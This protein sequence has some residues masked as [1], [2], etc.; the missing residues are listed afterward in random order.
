[1]AC[2]I[3]F[4]QPS[5]AGLKESLH[6]MALMPGIALLIIMT[7]QPENVR[8]L[9]GSP[10]SWVFSRHPQKNIHYIWIEITSRFFTYILHG[11]FARPGFAIGTVGS[12]GIE[13]IH[14]CKYAGSQGNLYALQAARI[15]AAI[16]SLVMIV[17]YI[18]GGN[19]KINFI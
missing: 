4:F 11:R 1:L 13:G 18:Y 17:G 15:A 5:I 19:K 7:R 2:E 10:N 9:D 6:W 16:P 3:H 14:Y 12:H 8:T